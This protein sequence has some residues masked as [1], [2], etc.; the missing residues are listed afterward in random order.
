M[1]EMNEG[2]HDDD[3]T[4]RLGRREG[5]REGGKKRRTV[6]SNNDAWEMEGMRAVARRERG[7]CRDV[8]N[9]GLSPC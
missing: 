5:G 7:M 2:V 9:V 6:K 1:N 3:E 4:Y 8:R